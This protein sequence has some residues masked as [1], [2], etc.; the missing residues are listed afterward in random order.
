M[1]IENVR[2]C[3]HEANTTG[4][5]MLGSITRHVME[6]SWLEC[7]ARGLEWTQKRNEFHGLSRDVTASF[8]SIALWEIMNCRHCKKGICNHEMDR[9]IHLKETRPFCDETIIELCVTK[10]ST[11]LRA[12][13]SW[14]RNPREN[15]FSTSWKTKSE[16]DQTKIAT[17][18]RKICK[19]LLLHVDLCSGNKRFLF[20]MLRDGPLVCAR[21]KRCFVW[22]RFAQ[23][24]LDRAHAAWSTQLVIILCACT[25]CSWWVCIDLCGTQQ[26]VRHVTGDTQKM[27]R[28]YAV[29]YDHKHWASPVPLRSLLLQSRKKPQVEE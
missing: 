4:D 2:L 9:D 18:H 26:S 20:A 29:C 28:E 8:L 25:P 21:E 14:Q 17:S 12:M 7:A 13:R 5:W 27:C 3:M 6:K 1:N 11:R 22:W 23:K 10:L 15:V 24:K 16:N 19:I